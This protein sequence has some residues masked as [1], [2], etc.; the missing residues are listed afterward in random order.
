MTEALTL[1]M[2]GMR[3]SEVAERLGVHRSTVYRWTTEPEFQREV[4]VYRE[5]LIEQCFDMQ[6]LVSK[7]AT[8]H[9]L[10]LIEDD[11][12]RVAI[13]AI[14]IAAPLKDT[15]NHIDRDKRLRFIEDNLDVT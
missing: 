10:E 12:P 8:I 11:N 13:P 14:R 4:R 2:R 9:L 15:Y 3:V 1:L 6:V 7:R 5:S